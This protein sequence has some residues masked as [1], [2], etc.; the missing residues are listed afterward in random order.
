M[1]YPWYIGQKVV[2]VSNGKCTGGERI[3]EGETYTIKNYGFYPE[4]MFAVSFNF[5]KTHETGEA[6]W[7]E[8]RFRPLEDNFAE[9]ALSKAI[10]QAKEVEEIMET[11][12][13]KEIAK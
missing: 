9:Q 3:V 2:C 11:Y 5:I 6:F 4:D 13:E 1:S 7:D 12:K 8:K 10:E